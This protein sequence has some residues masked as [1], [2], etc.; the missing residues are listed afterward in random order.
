MKK[1]ASVFL[2]VSSSVLFI[3]CPLGTEIAI[4][5]KPTVKV[6]PSIIGKWEA[7]N[8]TDYTYT[9]SKVDDYNYKIEKKTISS[10]DV[11][12]YGGFISEVLGENFFNIWEMAEG[13]TAKMYYLYK[14][15]MQ[16]GGSFIKL[17]PVTEN[18]DEKF[19]SSAELKKFIEKN[20]SLSFFYDKDENS[21]IKTGK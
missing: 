11:S 17:L 1:I 13:S 15:D 20:K 8:S 6:I 14:I 21:F 19:T 16:S 4:D 2:F 9:V 12:N 3:G 5:D 18:I 7:R 10:G